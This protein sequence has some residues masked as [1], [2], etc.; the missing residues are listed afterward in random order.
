MAGEKTKGSTKRVAADGTKRG[1]H[2]AGSKNR[3]TILL[4]ECQKEI[5]KRYGIKNYDP[6]KMLMLIAVDVSED[7]VKVDDKGRPM[8]DEDG[9]PIII[10]ADRTLA[11]NAAAKAAP[12]VRSQLKQIEVSEKDDGPIDADVVGA[13]AKLAQM[14][15]LAA[16]SLTDDGD[17]D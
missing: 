15:G 12:Y 6:V 11:V 5:E 10:A 9:N 8:L 2:K 7:R 3:A 13:K 17:G 16:D 4:E 14:A 1:L